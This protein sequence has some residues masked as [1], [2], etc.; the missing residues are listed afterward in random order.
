MNEV[1]S[2]AD[3]SVLSTSLMPEPVRMQV[4]DD[5]FG[6]GSEFYGIRQTLSITPTVEK[7]FLAIWSSLSFKRAALVQGN[8]AVGKKYT[9]TVM[10][11]VSR[12]VFQ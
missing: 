7:C 8:T 12:R 1:K 4:L 10:N 6:Y 3:S 5:T 2:S 9:I 11:I